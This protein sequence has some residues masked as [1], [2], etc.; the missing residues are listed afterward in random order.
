MNYKR[1]GRIHTG[2]QNHRCKD[3]GRQFV[4][5]AENRLISDA[6][7]ALVKRLLNERLSLR[8]ICRAVRVSLRW[9]VDFIVGCYAAAPD[10]LNVR[11]PEQPDEVIV[12]RLVVEAD[13]AW[14]F[15]RK[16]ANPQ[17]LWLALEV[18][19]RQVIAFYVGD[20]SRKSARKLWKKIPADYRQA[21][22]YTDGHA[23]YQ[24]VIPSTQHQVITKKAR[25]TNHVER[26]NCTLR[27]RV[28]RLVRATLSFSKKLDN[29]I[30]A[31]KY[32][33]SHYKLEVRSALPV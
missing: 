28:S 13:E 17:W 8:G 22:F 1:N 7:R 14:S 32:F 24:G 25:T 4:L 19:S 18:Q 30:G 23:S 11:L 26:L 12:Q 27:Q 2:K 29:H 31:I 20:R 33:L 10:D 16:K 5:S 6:E 3:C 21:T 15:V 9:L